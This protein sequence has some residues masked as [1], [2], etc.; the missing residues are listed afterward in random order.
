MRCLKAFI[1]GVALTFSLGA[2]SVFAAKA[3][4]NKYAAVVIDTKTGTVFHRE[5]SDDPRYPASTTK[6]MTLLLLFEALESKKVTLRTKLP[7]SAR[8]AKQPPCKLGLKAGTVITVNDALLGIVTKSAN[9]ASVAV[10]EY[11]AGSEDRFA[12]LMTQKARALGMKNTT[13][14]NAHGLHDVGQVTTAHDLARLGQQI[15]K[16]FPKYY[17]YFRTQAF[18]YNGQRH[19]NH[20][21]LLSKV[22]GV[23]G[24]KTGF[25][26]PA[27]FNLVASAQRGDKRIIAVVLGGDSGASR[28][29]RI[30]HLM[31]A[32]F[33][34]QKTDLPLVKEEGLTAPL[35]HA[36]YEKKS[37]KDLCRDALADGQDP[38]GDTI[39]SVCL[40]ESEPP[41]VPQKQIKKTLPHSDF[42][43]AK[44]RS[45]SATSTDR[46]V[47]K[48]SIQVGAYAKAQDAQN[49][50][51]LH[52]AAIKKIAKAKVSVSSSNRKRKRLYQAKLTGLTEQEAL[53]ACKMLAKT[54]QQ[55]LL[56]RPKAP[57][58][59]VSAENTRP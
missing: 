12:L 35:R 44:I 29:R 27:G 47:R 31:E 51:K 1:C 17:T 58:T 8:A 42:I 50:A 22:P 10:A 14:K 23:D 43:G 6:I 38:I 30:T 56:L 25:T 59:L 36:S 55:C 15:Y 52:L 3:P 24:I 37:S 7:V 39:R 26:N 5:F 45:V 41:A 13:F 32:A 46:P 20:N 21:K 2:S 19:N 53:A 57:S 4:K 34:G 9:D 28:D 48:W 49:A 40:K 18:W 16:R 11:L 54:G 33:K